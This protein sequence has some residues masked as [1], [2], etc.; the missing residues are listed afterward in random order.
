MKKYVFIL[1]ATCSVL[2]TVAQNKPALPDINKMMTMSPQELEAYKQ[3]M[4]KQASTQAKQIAATNN[5]KINEMLLPDFELNPPVKDIKRLSLLPVQPPTMIQLADGLKKSMQQL[6]SVTPKAVLDEVKTITTQQTPAQQQSSAVAEFYADNPVQALLISMNAALQNPGEVAGWN[7]L[8]ALYNMTGLEHKAIPILMH[9]LVQEPNNSMLLNNM[10]Q[11]FLG[12]G[13]LSKAEDFL[14]QCLIQDPLHPEANR[15]M[16][17]IRFFQN[18]FEE[19]QKYFEKELEVAHRRSTLANLKRKGIKIN[20]AAIRKRRTGIPH[21]DFFEEIGFSKF[22]LPDLPETAG[23]SAQWHAD[24]AVYLKSL[25]GELLFWMNAGEI[26]DEI[27]KEEGKRAPGFYAD[28]ESELMS[29]L[30]D[31]FAPLLGLLPEE[32]SGHLQDIITNYYT[33]LNEIKCPQPPN[34]PG[35]GEELILAYQQKCCDLKK[36]IADA[37]VSSRNA[38]I[39]NRYNIVN[40]RWKEYINAMISYVQLNP[41]AGNKKMVYHTVAEY[42]GFIG[43]TIATAVCFE[44]N[45]GGCIP[46]KMTSEEADG[47]IAA[48]H[49]IDFNCPNW[50]NMELDVQVAKIKA[51]CSKYALE[52]SA[53]VF[54]GGYEHNFKTGTSTLSAGV[55][56]KAKFFAGAGGADIKQMVYVSFDN[57]NEFGDFGLKG[58]ASVKVGDTPA[59]IA[60]GIAKVG[61]IVAGVEGGYT[62]GINS[63]FNSSVKGKGIIADFIKI[64]KSL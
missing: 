60:G 17:M 35:G 37:Y 47:I 23:Q 1:V 50:L 62:L 59:D 57:N 20:L 29:D 55:G 30:G 11:A 4:L 14:Q 41:T 9:H 36:P 33:K 45:P 7:N 2:I 26:T 56:V 61:G 3:K 15:S 27:R 54:R 6:Q 48:S 64:D 42:F 51:D 22:V 44:D 53:A 16:G 52:G 13:D 40:T 39:K 31:E 19:G 34:I 46:G 24:N 32:E 58:T 38:F 49:S 63:G 10:G 28:L 25:Q 18:Q 8:A 5:L 21:R 43:N 12:L